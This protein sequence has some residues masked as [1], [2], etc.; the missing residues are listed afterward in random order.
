MKQIYILIVVLILLT[1][2]V[3]AFIMSLNNSCACNANGFKYK[4]IN[5]IAT[6]DY[7]VNIKSDNGYKGINDYDCQ[8]DGVC[9]CECNAAMQKIRIEG[10]VKNNALIG[11]QFGFL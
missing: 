4:N 7:D 1:F 6:D 8:C 9:G 3:V 5:D 2:G 10:G 11:K